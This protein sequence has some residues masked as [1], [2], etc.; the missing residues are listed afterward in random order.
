M[1][2]KPWLYIFFVLLIVFLQPRV[3]AAAPNAA[4]QLPGGID[5]AR[6]N[7]AVTYGVVAAKGADEKL[8]LAG[9][10]IAIDAGHGG[11]DAGAVGPGGTKEKDVTLAISLGLKAL[12]EQD[13]A[14]VIMTRAKDQDVSLP[15]AT[16]AQ[17]L[18]ARADAANSAGA[19]LFLSIHADSFFSKEAGG[20]TSYFYPK[21]G[22][23]R[24]LAQFIQGNLVARLGLY[25]RGSRQGNLYVLKKTAMLAVLAEIAFVSNPAEEKMLNDKAFQDRAARGLYEGIKAYFA[26]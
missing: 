7:T 24:R 11:S 6:K 14:K 10:T 3:S 2:R 15:G 23:D 26:G 21:S 17:E 20:T 1:R 19:D 18:Q 12:L 22:E 9:K 16:P 25:D 4:P 13:G 8:P 5:A